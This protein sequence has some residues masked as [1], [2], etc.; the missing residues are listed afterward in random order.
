[1]RRQIQCAITT[2]TAKPASL[3][4]VRVVVSTISTQPPMVAQELRRQVAN[5]STSLGSEQD[6]P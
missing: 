3:R 6:R 4:G 2:A 1:M 5:L